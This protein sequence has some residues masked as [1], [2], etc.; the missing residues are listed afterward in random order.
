MLIMKGALLGILFFVAAMV[1]SYYSVVPRG[2]SGSV[3]LPVDFVRKIGMLTTGFGLG[4]L[5][6]GAAVWWIA[7]AAF[8]HLHNLI[9]Q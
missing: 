4:L 8:T 6:T 3:Q 7:Q 9:R 1:I 5:L 2:I